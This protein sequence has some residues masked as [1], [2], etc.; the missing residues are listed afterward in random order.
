MLPRRGGVSSCTLF[1]YCD[2]AWFEC[3]ELPS[4]PNWRKR[5]QQKNFA[6]PVAEREITRMGRWELDRFARHGL[7]HHPDMA[8]LLRVSV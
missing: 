7:A 4:R 6:R 2:D 8:R 5:M 3:A 1:V